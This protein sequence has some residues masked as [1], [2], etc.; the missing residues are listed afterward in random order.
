MKQ[1][2]LRA[3]ACESVLFALALLGAQAQSAQ[4]DLTSLQIEDL[5]NVDVTSASKTEQKTSGVPAAIFVITQEDIRRSG[6][7]NIP[8][9]LRMVPGLDVAQVTPS[10]RAISARG[11]NGQYSHMLSVLIDGRFNLYQN[12]FSGKP[13]ATRL[14]KNPP[15]M[16]LLMP[17]VIAN[18]ASNTLLDADLAWQP[19]DKMSLGLT[20]QTLLQDV[21]KE[22]LRLRLDGDAK[23]CPPEC[24]C[25]VHVAVLNARDVI[26]SRRQCLGRTVRGFLVDFAGSSLGGITRHFFSL[27][28]MG[29]EGTK[30]QTAA[31]EYRVKAAFIFHFAQL[32][33]WPSEKPAGAANSRVLCTLG[34]DPFQGALED[35]VA[36]KAIGKPDPSHSPPWGST[37]YAGPARSSFSAG[38]EQVHS[39]VGVD[40][41]QCSSADGGRDSRLSRCGWNYR[42]SPRR[43]QTS[44]RGQSRY[45]RIGRS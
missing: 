12:L 1:I 32:V 25:Q 17:V 26:G 43:Q 27:V 20:G 37:R 10:V 29:W 33:D 23:P 6:T 14:E 24:L 2:L 11:F 36:G 44:F 8:D 38:R 35:T 18:F 40:I 9:L 34:E 42:L 4:T 39:Y 19:L 28:G 21:H 22:L 16:H 41:A 31:E 45:R 7:T 30:A 13:G 3:V 5:M 15:T